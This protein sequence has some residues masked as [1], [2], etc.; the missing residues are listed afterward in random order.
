MKLPQRNIAVQAL[1][2][3]TDEDAHTIVGP[4]DKS[5]DSDAVIDETVVVSEKTSEVS[6]ASGLSERDRIIAEAFEEAERKKAESGASSTSEADNASSNNEPASENNEVSDSTAPTNP[7]VTA[8]GEIDEN[9]KIFAAC[10]KAAGDFGYTGDAQRLRAKELYQS[11]ISE[12]EKAKKHA[13]AAERMQQQMGGGG[14]PGITGLISNFFSK[15]GNSGKLAKAGLSERILNH[16]AHQLNTNFHTM[17]EN[18]KELDREVSVLNETFAKS[19]GGGA[20]AEI[21]TANNKSV[22]DLIS[23]IES[24]KN[25]SV[26][27]RLALENAMSNPDFNAQWEKVTETRL[28]LSEAVD[29]TSSSFAK[30]EKSHGDRFDSE[31]F[32]KKMEAQLDAA[33]KGNKPI[34]GTTEDKNLAKDFQKHLDDMME[35][36]RKAIARVLDKVV[37]IFAK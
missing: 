26:Q 31:G 10:L 19:L 30:L 14:A 25:T 21:A 9:D 34:A 4:I 35:K 17:S 36:M 29:K 2:D 3:K 16:R 37:Q 8:E 28:K 15:S 11:Q 7:E 5:A 20:L 32:S 24:G 1:I 12:K 13:E 33:I 22:P 23:D 18:I 6:S 27:A